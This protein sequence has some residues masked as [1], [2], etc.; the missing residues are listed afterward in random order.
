MRTLAQS[1]AL[2][3][4][5]AT[6]SGSA[7]AALGVQIPP[8]GPGQVP[9]YFGVVPNYATSPQP[10]L[11]EVAI[12]DAGKGG[13]A[14][15]TA[16]VDP[17]TGALTAVNAG[18]TGAGYV[19]PMV[20]L[21][22][23]SLANGAEAA[24][25][26]DFIPLG[27]ITQLSATVPANS[28]FTPNASLPVNLVDTSG[29]GLGAQGT[30]ITDGA[31]AIVSVSVTT[32]G[33]GYSVGGSVNLVDPA[34]P[35]ADQPAVVINAV[36]D[37][38]L[39]SIQVINTGSGY[40]S[41]ATVTV[42]D[43]AGNGSGATAAVS[44]DANGAISA[45][46][47]LTVGTGYVSPRI[48]I[49]DT[50]TGS[51]AEVT[52][53]VA[54]TGNGNGEITG[55]TIVS[56]GSGY[57]NPRVEV[58][59]QVATGGSGAVVAAT[60]YD[61][62]NGVQ[63]DQIKDIQ[64]V[65]GGTGY[66]AATEVLIKGFGPNV[67]AA[68]AI[69]VISGGVITG[70]N[71]VQPGAGYDTPKTGTGIRKFVDSL[72][73]L[74]LTGNSAGN[75]LGQKLPIATP[76][77][78]TEVNGKQSDYYELAE[79]EYTKKLHSDLPA[80]HLRGYVQIDPQT[81]QTIGEPQVLGPII[82]A[83]KDRP[84][85]IKLV[86]RLS[87]G[88]AGN[89]PFPVDHTYMG[90]DKAADTDNRTA[91]HLHGGN[92]PWISDGLPRQW[93]KPAG[94]K[95]A[96]RGESARD[97]P[98]MWF[99][100]SG[101][102][103]LSCMGQLTCSVAGATNNPGEGALTFYYTN[104]Q[105][106]R[107]MFYHDHA[108]GITRL[109]VY[110]G[111]AGGYVLQD[112]K[113]Q[114]LVTSGVLPPLADTIPLVIQERTFVPDDTTPVLNFYGAFKSQLNAQDSTWRWGG[115]TGATGQNGPGD[116]W[117][118]H[119]FM[120]NQ[121]PGDPSGA[122]A[123]GRWDYGP[124]FWPPRVGLINGPLENPY[125]DPA[126]NTSTGDGVHPLLGTCEGRFIP[127]TPNGA[128]N[129]YGG[130]SPIS[131]P[132]GTPESFND[133]P[134]VN[135]TVY[136]HMVVKPK[137]YRL[138]FLTAGNDR[139]LNLSLVVAASNQSD[140]T[141]AGNTG[142]Q[143][144]GILCDGK[145]G[146]SDLLKP[147]GASPECTEVRM[148]PFDKSQ[149]RSTPF[150]SH[151][152]SPLNTG[153]TF[154]GRTGGVFD[155]ATRGPAMIQIGTEGGFLASP[156]V[157]KNQPVNYEYNAK[158]IVV[159]S[160]KEHALLLGP[161]ERADVVVDFS[162]FKGS[163]IIL[164][165]D[166]PAALP[167]GDLRLDY[168][169]GDPDN[170]DSGGT[171][172]T[173]PGYGP[174]SRT[175]MQFRVEET[176]DGASACDSSTTPDYVDSAYLSTL[177]SAV[178]NAFKTSQEPIVVPQAAYNP[179][180][181]TNVSDALGGSMSSISDKQM[182]FKPLTVDGNGMAT[183]ALDSQPIS[184]AFQPK[185]I[186]ED[187]TLDFGR[188][189]ATLGVEM[190]HTTAINQTSMPQGY[191]DP[192]TELVKI[193]HASTPITGVM[194][195]GTQ[196]WKI[197]HN[198]VDTHPIHFHLFS[199]QLL[200]RV[201]WDGAVVPPE[202][203]EVGWKE[204][205]RMNPLQD[206]IVALRPK[207]MDLPFKIANSHRT[208]DPGNPSTT[209]NPAMSFNLDPT[210]GNGSNVTNLASNF[211]W[212]YIW[213]CHILGHE[214]NDMMRS[215]AV[216][217]EPEAPTLFKASAVTDGVI[218]D[219]FDNSMVSN[220]VSIQRSTD[221][222]F[223]QNLTTFNVVQDECAS[224]TGCTR[225]FTD[226]TAAA[227][228]TYYYKLSSNNTVG[229]GNGMVE[230]GYNPASG[231]WNTQLAAVTDTNGNPARLTPGFIGYGSVTANSFPVTTQIVYGPEANL[232]P[233]SLNF[234]T[235]SMGQTSG[236]RMVALS[237]NGGATLNISSVS[238]SNPAFV[239]TTGAN[240]CGATLAAKGTCNLYLTF[241][242][243]SAAVMN[244]TLTLTD[245]VNN[246]TGTTG[247]TGTGLVAVP[248]AP[249][250]SAITTTGLTLNWPAVGGATSYT[251]Q[252]A[253]NV[254]FTG[255]V[256]TP[257]GGASLNVTGL[258]AGTT[259][260]FRVSATAGTGSSAYSSALS[261]VTLPAAPAT[262]TATSVLDSRLTLNWGAVASATGY[263]VQYA[264]NNTF[265]TGLVTLNATTNSL[266]VTG[267]TAN[268]TYY[269]R[270]SATNA[271]GNGANSA[272]LTQKTALAAPTGLAASNV[273]TTGMTVSWSSVAGATRYTVQ[274]ASN[275]NFT[276]TVTTINVNAPATSLAVTGLTA[277][278]A[279]YYRVSVTTGAG[280]SANSATLTQ[281]T[282]AAA[283]A[284][285]TTAS[286]TA[287][288]LTLNWTA[289]TGATG[290][291]VQSA[292]NNT[293]TTGLVTLNATTNSLAVTGLS[294]NTT[295]YFR[296]SV[297]TAAGTSAYSAMRT[298][299]MLP[300]L[301]SNLSGVNGT[302]GGFVA[303]GGIWTAP[304]GGATSYNLR[305]A[306]NNGMTT[307]VQTFPN[308]TSNSRVYVTT[309]G[310]NGIPANTTVYLQVQAVNATGATA[311]TPATPVAVTAIAR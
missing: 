64:V 177:T 299:L 264:T 85:R 164:Y 41:R 3:C 9:D 45:V 256:T 291:T 118:P 184:L 257:A 199:V 28:G 163:T 233:T 123:V 267:L 52:P 286:V 155:P 161:A 271:A 172:S 209:M 79:I 18:A 294:A 19:N 290:Y 238:S 138:R 201:G 8:P 205:V 14:T 100:A 57:R 258:T 35:A 306:T 200:N 129:V 289:V 43:G 281:S 17:D 132:S 154:D 58:I 107:M 280:T 230:G 117:V 253:T 111:L 157:I 292:T 66:T 241:T 5:A 24:P 133:T 215:I 228:T 131:E 236:V 235:V 278:T 189:N 247:L 119:V 12:T 60:T 175:L 83:Q 298:Q 25:G 34:N 94:E 223:N 246:V 54:D 40:S 101:K 250:A 251:V 198:G 59:D 187:W 1:I 7:F 181:G 87:T 89:L 282:L 141:E 158:N 55:Y 2:I 110:A 104:Q 82:V 279:Y 162:K 167:A 73:T 113:E 229:A 124:W 30:A 179:V 86:N 293:F 300:N 255:A 288:G 38:T 190:P 98:D 49:G 169:T 248:A 76:T 232:S 212:E 10:V 224:Q 71:L 126:C 97:V 191:I 243:T 219:W 260:W 144:Q 242:P 218:L 108:E 130:G 188:M 95:G 13:G 156:A 37:G 231:A 115:G 31:G 268:T 122:N 36:G 145:S 214:E 296:V 77:I 234:G 50:V 208:Q 139:H 151:W 128:I 75:N 166:A 84:V 295:Y 121:N 185:S 112:A 197:T 93:I 261:Q 39:N 140:T 136:P 182:T 72:S 152:Y 102:A 273:T 221:S 194:P 170:T 106:Q 20:I 178:R 68:K 88:E 16:T 226:K 26:P 6:I 153:V 276:G 53:T 270:V 137:K 263:T 48:V 244:G 165:N 147:A 308:A 22:D 302:P 284:A 78:L 176:C 120:P 92:T 203:N 90:A 254:N 174:N 211:G 56:A 304:T 227:K 33:V 309:F 46:N 222:G 245:S 32:P 262:P 148:V 186:V 42:E 265:T 311:W 74:D 62:A 285:P 142:S 81:G 44:V 135:G 259:Y 239:R 173:L 275:A 96:N 252:R 274:R 210:T 207:T 272:T 125:Y 277:N 47:I 67:T 204:I 80:T 149:N 202:S 127:G 180:Y 69:P 217:A 206:V 105:S 29:A 21:T 99:D 15:A 109:N 143:Q 27:G 266:A 63:T 146:K 301:P 91:M 159:G 23:V 61:Y 11:T 51:G 65:D 287:S 283:P 307:K 310:P 213:H 150:P 171:F 216:A 134:L 225:S 4:S 249:G 196:I 160:V 193:S 116:L 237:N 103:L 269:F 192:A 183:G 305:I 240:D 195:D 303:V 70:F 220:W 168:F 297:T 114:E